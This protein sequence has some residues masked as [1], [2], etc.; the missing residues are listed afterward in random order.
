MNG[1]PGKGTSRLPRG[2][3]HH[4]SPAGGALQESELTPSRLVFTE[5][6][7]EIQIFFGDLSP[8]LNVA[9]NSKALKDSRQT[10]KNHP[11]AGFY[12]WLSFVSSMAG[13]NIPVHWPGQRWRKLGFWSKEGEEHRK[14][15]NPLNSEMMGMGNRWRQSEG[16]GGGECRWMM[17]GL[18]VHPPQSVSGNPHSWQ[19]LFHRE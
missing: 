7:T 5:K 6:G 10:S 12:T 2:D 17:W 9:V 16:K 14:H 4:F 8:V 19:T 11:W 3:R 15:G 18:S 13:G 1:T